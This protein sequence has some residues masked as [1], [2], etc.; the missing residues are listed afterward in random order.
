MWLRSWWPGPGRWRCEDATVPELSLTGK[1]IEMDEWEEA[2]EEDGLV[3]VSR[4]GPSGE[5]KDK[6]CFVFK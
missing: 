6:C 4:C 1:A 3:A 2:A 5:G